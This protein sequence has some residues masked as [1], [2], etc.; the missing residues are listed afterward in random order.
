MICSCFKHIVDSIG[1]VDDAIEKNEEIITRFEN[2][3]L[4]LYEQLISSK[5]KEIKVEALNIKY[6]V[7]IPSNQREIGK[8]PLFAS[9]GI[10][11]YINKYNSS[12]T[13]ILGCR[14]T[15]GSV[16]YCKDN[17]FVL[18][19][20]FF[21]ESKELYGNLYFALKHNKGFKL[22]ATGAAQPQITIENIQNVNIKIPVNNYLNSILDYIYMLQ[23]KNNNLKSIKQL[24]LNKYFD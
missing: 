22:Y 24:L 21:I 12:N 19:T 1:S 9:N 6:G 3:G 18:N 2:Y 16:F 20:A 10:T 13:I 15:V 14:G 17:N 11:D 7:S 5:Y 8:Y 23:I 4:K